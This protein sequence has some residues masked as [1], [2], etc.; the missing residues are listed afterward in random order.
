[1]DEDKEIIA[2]FEPVQMHDLDI[3]VSVG[4][5]THPLATPT[6]FISHTY[7]HG[8]EVSVDAIASPG[9]EFDRWVGD[10][11]ASHSENPKITLTMDENK[12][13]K[14]QFEP[15]TVHRL[16]IDINTENALIDGSGGTTFPLPNIPNFYIGE[17]EET[18]RAIPNLGAS[19]KGWSGDYEGKD[20]EITVIMDSDKSL[21]ANF[22]TPQPVADLGEDRTVDEEE[23]MVLVNNQE[24]RLYQYE[25]DFGDGTKIPFG[26]P[27][28]T[29]NYSEPGNYNVELTVRDILGREDIDEINVTVEE[30]RGTNVLLLDWLTDQG[31][32][33]ARSIE[34]LMPDIPLS[35]YEYETA[36]MLKDDVEREFWAEINS[37]EQFNIITR[38]LVYQEPTIDGVSYNI[39]HYLE[40]FGPAIIILSDNFLNAE[41]RWNF[42][43]EQRLALINH[44]EDGNALM[45]TGGSLNDLRLKSPEGSMEIGQW[46]HTSRLYLDNVESIQEV[47]ENYRASLTAAMGLGLFPLYQEAREWIAMALEKMYEASV[48]PLTKPLLFAAATVAYSV[49]LLPDNVPFDA[50]FSTME[51]ERDI[52]NGLGNEFELNLLNRYTKGKEGDLGNLKGDT[53]LTSMG[54]QLQYPFLMAHNILNGTSEGDFLSDEVHESLKENLSTSSES[55]NQLFDHPFTQYDFE[56]QT[57][58]GESSLTTEDLRTITENI[59]ESLLQFLEDMYEARTDIPSQI[60]LDINF[61]IGNH[62]IDETIVIPIPVPLQK[63]FRPAEIAT[64]SEDGRAAI[65]KYEIDGQRYEFDSDI[66]WDPLSNFTDFDQIRDNVLEFDPIE[67]I[68]VSYRT[69]Y[70]TF[71]PALGDGNSMIL[72]ENTLEWLEDVPEPKPYEL[73]GSMDVPEYLVERTRENYPIKHG[74]IVDNRSILLKKDETHTM[75]ITVEETGSLQV[76][77][78]GAD[79]VTL[80]LKHNEKDITVEPERYEYDGYC[81]RVFKLEETGDWTLEAQVNAEGLKTPM[82]VQTTEG[83][84][85]EIAEIK[86]SDFTVSPVEGNPPLEVDIT[87]EIENIGYGEGTVSLFAD[88][89]E[90]NSWTLGPSDTVSVD[91]TYT[92]DEEGEFI[93]ELSGE[94]QT[95]N[96]EQGPLSGVDFEVTNFEVDPIEG[97]P[98]VEVTVTADIE[99][100]G[101]SEGT[102]EL[103]IDDDLKE[104]WILTPDQSVSIEEKFTMNDKGIFDFELSPSEEDIQ[105]VTIREA[106]G[107]DD[108]TDDGDDDSPLSYWWLFLILAIA[109]ILMLA[110]VLMKKKSKEEE[111][112]SVEGDAWNP[113]EDNYKEKF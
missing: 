13:I 51:S 55:F 61:T 19:F 38:P 9:Y 92:F 29:H 103:L 80:T 24:A 40:K 2:N 18:I 14:A 17:E 77:W 84:Y 63:L 111:T 66:S 5:F 78:S 46:D 57:F 11:P 87:A 105:T 89:S 73:I 56:N 42:D 107:E 44:L 22:E 10:V 31:V 23:I 90:V 7:E 26:T 95:I 37:G 81:S 8:T 110:Q 3:D 93:V 30:G 85:E 100:T 99:N 21:T 33:G 20:D 101:D 41:G 109:V 35:H 36:P 47:L 45:A 12:D 28:T 43:K 48:D 70:F 34:D 64:R 113:K 96:V 104:E 6:D 50:E 102:I 65:L 88:Y 53:E 4:G 79:E 112:S 86:V 82:M 91:E 59:T 67:E 75:D 49:P 72:V 60:E 71:N 62:T 69:A 68:P 108:E 27:V 52:T 25:W 83:D 39:E 98:G 32:V 58:L 76:Y 97:G 1:M 74:D 106:D 94:T 16:G 15:I 54:W